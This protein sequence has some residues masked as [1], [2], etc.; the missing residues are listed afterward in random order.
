MTH[1]RTWDAW[2]HCASCGQL[3]Q[4]V[5]PHCGTA[6]TR[7]PLAEYLAA[8]EPLRDSRQPR[9]QADHPAQDMRDAISGE[10]LAA[11][12]RPQVWLV[13]PQCDEAF[14]PQFYRYCPICGLDGGAGL[15]PPPAVAGMLPNRVLLVIAGLVILGGVLLL[16]F[17]SLFR[18]D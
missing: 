4:T 3:R 1:S 14:A 13:C 9:A 17:W 10:E 15:E 11:L 6:G 7:F 2:P 12:G 18:H 8:G 5:C 16:Y